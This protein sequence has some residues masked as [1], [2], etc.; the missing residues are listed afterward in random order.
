MT[1]LVIGATGPAGRGILAAAKDAG[2]PVRALARRPKVLSGVIADVAKGN[3]PDME[4]FMMLLRAQVPS[5]RLL[6][7]Y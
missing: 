5:F 4:A 6:A 3:V 1:L 7:H 2:V